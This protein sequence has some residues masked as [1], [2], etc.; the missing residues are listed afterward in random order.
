VIPD[1]VQLAHGP[2][3]VEPASWTRLLVMRAVLT[4]LSVR[5]IPS[6][7]VLRSQRSNVTSMRNVVPP[8][9][10]SALPALRMMQF[11]TFS[12]DA[13]LIW[14]N[15]SSA[16]NPVMLRTGPASSTCGAIYVNDIE[17]SRLIFRGI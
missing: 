2:M 6:S 12:V 8:F 13:A 9:C 17:L 3:H 10:R 1:D 7:I 16:L 4:E 11:D 14:K 5:K 15:L